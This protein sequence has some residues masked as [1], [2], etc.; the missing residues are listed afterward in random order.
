MTLNSSRSRRWTAV[1]VFP[2][3][4][5]SLWGVE[6]AVLCIGPHGSVAVE[7]EG[8]DGACMGAEPVGPGDR[9]EVARDCAHGASQC[10]GCTDIALERITAAVHGSGSGRRWS[11]SLP[12]V[13]TIATDEGDPDDARASDGTGRRR[14]PLLSPQLPLHLPSTVLRR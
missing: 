5:A 2:F 14:S 6:G 3:L 10:S 4:Y 8:S 9:R 7:S 13:L 12:L 11:G 1:A